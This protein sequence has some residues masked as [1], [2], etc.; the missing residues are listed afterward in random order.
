MP[1]DLYLSFCAKIN[2]KWIE[3]LKRR[4]D[5][6]NLKEQKVRTKLELIHIGME[7]LKRYQQHRHEDQ[8]LINRTPRS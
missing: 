8:Q 6:L 7:F 2:S 1:I 5:T 3:D 4:P